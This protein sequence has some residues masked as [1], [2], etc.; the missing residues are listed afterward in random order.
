[1]T[2]NKQDE[3]AKYSLG[4]AQ[5]AIAVTSDPLTTLTCAKKM[6]IL[7]LLRPLLTGW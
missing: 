3:V 1:M 5:G 2:Q 6:S 7:V 4:S